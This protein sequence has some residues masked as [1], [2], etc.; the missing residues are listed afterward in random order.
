MPYKVDIASFGVPHRHFTRTDSTNSRARELAAAGASHGT[1]VTAAEQTAGRGRR[2]HT[3]TAPPNKALLYSA[4]IRPLEERH[5]M[6]PLAVP[7]AVCEAAEQLNPNLECKVKWPNDIHVDGRKL[8]GVLIEARPQDGWAVIGIGLN[9]FI[10]I[11]EFPPELRDTA[12]SLFDPGHKGGGRG[13][14]GPS[15]LLSAGPPP[16]AP[17]AAAEVL[18]QRLDHWTRVKPDE[19]LAT[20]RER[21]ALLGRE[22]EW[23][24]GS[25]VADG[26]D[27]RGYLVVVTSSGDRITVGAGEVHL[28]RF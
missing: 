28:T 26:V 1:V 2:G 25:G 22:V 15:P 14:A 7:L 24:A 6:L 21:D 10:S 17:S 8:A 5:M 9:L 12:I 27:D 18:S 20:W 11:E 3:W 13:S 23:E 4:I 19:V 16:S